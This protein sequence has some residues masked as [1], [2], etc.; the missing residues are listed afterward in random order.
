[1]FHN[2]VGKYGLSEGMA[3]VK[4]LCVLLALMLCL[5]VSACS[6]PGDEPRVTRKALSETQ[7]IATD[8][9][10]TELA[11]S[12]ETATR[13]NLERYLGPSAIHQL[14]NHS[15][16]GFER[17]RL[18]RIEL[19]QRLRL[20]PRLPADH[21]LARDLTIAETA[22]VDLIALEQL[23]YGRFSYRAL[24]PYAVD[25]YSG[26]WLEGPR[27]LAY[28][29]ALNTTTDALAFVARL[30]ALS[31]AV[32]DTRRRLIADQSSG[33]QM[34]RLLARETQRRV[35]VLADGNA[36]ALEEISV[37]FDALTLDVEDLEPQQR[38][39]LSALVSDEVEFNLRPAYRRLGETL[40]I[41]AESAPEQ[42]GIWAQPEGLDL[43][44]GILKAATGARIATGRL[45]QRHIDAVKD[46]R[47]ALLQTISV[48]DDMLEDQPER[49]SRLLPWY[50]EVLVGRSA[51]IQPAFVSDPRIEQVAEGALVELPQAKAPLELVFETP[52]FQ[53]LAPALRDFQNLLVQPPY[54]DWR[55]K[56]DGAL[57]PY[58][59][60]VEYP[61]ILMGSRLYAWEQR[62]PDLNTDPLE[63]LAIQSVGLILSA[64]AAADTGLHLERWSVAQATE[65]LAVNTGLTEPLCRQLALRAAASPGKF[66]AA[67]ASYHRLETL[68][69]RA[70]AVLGDRY[71]AIEFQ[72]IVFQPGP[73]P[74]SIIETDIEAWYAEE[75]RN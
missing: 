5:T 58:R 49:L 60:I 35:E 56:G 61:A 22:L 42:T 48:P 36:A 7:T 64:L 75:L 68:S 46:R 37:I 23:G 29:H 30:K 57:M 34:P 33:I 14:D 32:D 66:A 8:F 16:A 39:Q 4:N 43:Y 11:L 69:E 13:L 18:L 52:S 21:A 28:E 25:P 44:L 26:I 41:V 3:F 73:R 17:R 51:P 38:L 53:A 1:M 71:S 74:L 54:L 70:Q 15:Q 31:Q 9:L 40:Q 27:L 47:L 19:L 59:E 45:H 50:E 65:Y 67:M 24:R 20:R 12:P 6:D 2:S 63:A 10:R 55:T 62:V 72:R